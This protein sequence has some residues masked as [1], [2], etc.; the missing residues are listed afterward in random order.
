MAERAV[1]SDTSGREVY[2][3]E[4][5]ESWQARLA[6]ARARRAVVL[7]KKKAGGVQPKER[8]KPWEEDG[9]V[10]FDEPPAAD[11]SSKSGAG[12]D[13]HDRVTALR[14]NEPA[15][16]VPT[17]PKLVV[18]P[19]DPCQE[20][21]AQKSNWYPD[22]SDDVV[23]PQE[24][25]TYYPALAPAPPEDMP[26]QSDQGK[27]SKVNAIFEEPSFTRGAWDKDQ[28]D[29]GPVSL[30]LRPE[31][32]PLDTPKEPIWRQRMREA[33]QEEQEARDAEFVAAVRIDEEPK[34]PPSKWRGR[35]AILAFVCAAAAVGPILQ[36]TLNAERGPLVYI[37]PGIGNV[38]PLGT[39]TAM[40][41]EPAATQ[42]G[43][44]TPPSLRAPRQPLQVSQPWVPQRI[45]EP[46]SFAVV[47]GFGPSEIV[48][49]TGDAIKPV[50]ISGRSRSAN[51]VLPLDFVTEPTLGPSG[52]AVVIDVSRIGGPFPLPRPVGLASRA[53]P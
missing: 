41:R 39:T 45:G 19:V 50:E 33:E 14:K 46:A 5:D 3:V 49:A 20:V 2:D 27:S 43:E 16:P 42:S 44:W 53:R 6:E 51:A 26:K 21:P 25:E 28:D 15:K 47:P 40:V 8:L 24:S 29:N 36:F 4:N 12:L 23:E 10:I 7:E 30:L 17:E 22:A 48:V 38:L 31:E 35:F 52:I 1:K 18:A 9:A 32:T 37:S 11:P 34:R 13:F